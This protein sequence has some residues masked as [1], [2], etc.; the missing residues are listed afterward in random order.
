MAGV[1]VGAVTIPLT[2]AVVVTLTDVTEPVAEDAAVGAHEALTAQEAVANETDELKFVT[3][4]ETD[5]L[6][7][8]N[9]TAAEDDNAVT[10]PLINCIDADANVNDDDIETID[11]VIAI[12]V[13]VNDE[14]FDVICVANDELNGAIDALRACKEAEV[15]AAEDEIA[16]IEAVVAIIV[17]VNEAEFAVSA[18]ENDA[19]YVCAFVAN[20]AVPLNEPV[21]LPLKEAVIELAITLPEVFTLN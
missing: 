12:T 13:V 4:V 6:K 8:V 10:D 21:K 9:A 20:E 18:V 3:S 7:L 19:E 5:A 14:L 2:P 16:T 17:V 1:V 11:A 15:N